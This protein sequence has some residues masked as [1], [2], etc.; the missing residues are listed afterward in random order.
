M[1]N[2]K[3]QRQ[4]S[5]SEWKLIKEKE[6]KNLLGEDFS[7]IS[8]VGSQK[9][10]T[11]LHKNCGEFTT[12]WQSI[13]NNPYCR[14]CKLGK[15]K[16]KVSSLINKTRD[17]YE[18]LLKDENSDFEI[19]EY[20]GFS[21]KSVIRHNACGRVY[22]IIFS[23]FWAYK[24]CAKC[25]K[26]SISLEK[27]FLKKYGHIFENRNYTYLGGY[28]GSSTKIDIKCNECNS[29]YSVNARN[30]YAN[31]VDCKC[32]RRI[33]GSNQYTKATTTEQVIQ[34]N[35]RKLQN[36]FIELKLNDEFEVKWETFVNNSSVLLVKH[37]KCGRTL[38]KTA[39]KI[40]LGSCRYCSNKHQLSPDEY[41]NKVKTITNDKYI[42]LDDY[43]NNQTKL[44]H[45]HIV[46]ERSWLCAPVKFVNEGVRCPTCTKYESKGERK[47][48]EFFEKH[49]IE[50][51]EQYKISDCKNIYSL[52]FD[53]AIFVNKELKLLIEF[54]GKQHFQPV[55]LFGGYENFKKLQKNDN[56]KNKYC[57]DNNIDLLRISYRSINKIDEI[58]TKVVRNLS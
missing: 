12:S 29:I 15:E 19:I 44:M 55:E 14:R 56:I 34:E 47:I 45:K 52:P 53:F 33:T 42:C 22:S 43:K 57:Q 23:N 50:Y 51:S 26:D 8:Y 35:L 5:L 7:L 13:K 20:S 1:V 41:K 9:S 27:V 2:S 10:A 46:C 17:K 48:R 28:R 32:R 49:N 30:F 16:R 25:E 39:N 24:K 54:D 4:R 58:L 18:K 6:L 31:N 11:F 36:K 3:I 40:L 38:S 21:K 37:R